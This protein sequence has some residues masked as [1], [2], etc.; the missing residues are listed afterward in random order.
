MQCAMV[1]IL[2]V[3][4][5]VIGLKTLSVLVVLRNEGQNPASELSKVRD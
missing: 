3:L 5:T 1:K 4:F 2:R